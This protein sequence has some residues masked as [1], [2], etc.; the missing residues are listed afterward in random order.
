MPAQPSLQPTR[1]PRSQVAMLLVDVINPFQFPGADRM[2]PDI[3]EAARAIAQLKRRM[4]Q[5]GAIAVYANDNY[6][7]WHSEFSD[8]LGNCQALPGM[9]G[10]VAQMLAPD[11]QDLRVLKPQHSGFHSTPLQHLL[12]KMGVK[13]VVVVGFITDMCVFTTATDACMLG[14]QVAV[15]S[16]CTASVTAERKSAALAQLKTAFG[17]STAKGR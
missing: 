16:D 1:L 12:S 13:K 8:V 11:A 17:C 6:G 5:R 3:L 7:T 14:Y 2:L 9:R 4:R 10:D 15:P